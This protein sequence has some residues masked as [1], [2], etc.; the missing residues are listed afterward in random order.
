LAGFCGRVAQQLCNHGST[1]LDICF[2]KVKFRVSWKSSWKIKKE[3]PSQSKLQHGL[4]VP[5]HQPTWEF[6][7]LLPTNLQHNFSS[8]RNRS[9]EFLVYYDEE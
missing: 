2:Q 5:A 4:A 3:L 1:E 6:S 7:R 8:A 9:F